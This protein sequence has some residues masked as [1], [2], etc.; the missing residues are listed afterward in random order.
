[1]DQKY[2][3]YLIHRI[4]SGKNIFKYDNILYELH[5]PSLEL[6]LQSDLV[7]NTAYNDNLYGEFSLLEDIPD[8][9]INIGLISPDYQKQIEKTEKALENDK[10]ALFHNFFDLAKRKRNKLK[11]QQTKKRWREPNL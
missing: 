6:R 7:Y 5:K 8:M 10:L 4:L 1:M 2:I 9:V 3:E 11:I